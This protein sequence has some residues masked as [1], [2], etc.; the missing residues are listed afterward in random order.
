VLGVLAAFWPALLVVVLVAIRTPH[1]VK[2]LLAFLAGGLLTCLV[3]GM[4]AVRALSDTALVTKD[5]GT[6]DA[7]VYFA[8]AALVLLAAFA[9]RRYG[10]SPKRAAKQQRKAASDEPSWA[11]RYVAKGGLLAFG[12]GI[13]LNIVPGFVPLIALTKL[14]ELDL[15]TATTFAVLLVFYV[16][17]F[18]FVE[19]PIVGYLVAPDWTRSAVSRFN[20]WLNA[21]V[22][23]VLTWALAVVAA[24][25]AARGVASL[26]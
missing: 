16:I 12:A 25:L 24:A 8:G 22:W 14:A 4:S 26:T 2:L 21:N 20:E 10:E 7:V 6:T 18:S 11:E 15:D 13:V 5:R 9:V 23:R 3:I 19:V 17:M 1:P